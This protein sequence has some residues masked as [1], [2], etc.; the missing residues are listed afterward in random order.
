MEYH[1]RRYER[2]P[3]DADRCDR[4]GAC[5]TEC[6]VM[7]MAQ[8]DAEHVISTLPGILD[9]AEPDGVS[10]RALRDCTSCFTCNLVCP[11]DCR[12][13]N[14]FL[15]IWHAQYLREGLP[16]RARYFLPH[17]EPNFR[18]YVIDRLPAR[19][20]A[21]LDAWKSREPVKEI[22]FPGCNIVTT[23]YLTFSRLF[24]GL[25]I[26]GALEFCCGEMYFRMGL[27]EQMEQV[28]RKN[29][30][31]F[32][33][34][35]V[36]KVH[37]LCTAGL[38]LFTHVLPQFGA[39]F[40][41]IAFEPF[42]KRVHGLLASGELPIVKRFDGRTVTVQDSCHSKIFEEDFDHWPRRV[43]EL[44]GFEIVEAPESGDRMHCCGIAS[45]FSHDSA[46]SKTGMIRGQRAC[47]KNAREPGT[48]YIAAYCAGCMQMMSVARFMA[49]GAQPVHHVIE[50]V[51]EAIG[52]RPVRRQQR[53]AW[54]F[55]R[56]TL[57]GQ[58]IIGG[59]FFV[60]PIE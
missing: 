53:I 8:D 20:K 33:E 2:Q 35:G 59:R 29:T 18:T 39:D 58:K 9:G 37:M 5:L 41:G 25:P 13:A 27:Y 60:P 31:W 6:P 11:H 15:D 17:C 52:E 4:C 28:A 56:G 14:L 42:M 38:N 7:H 21:A 51:Q 1:F 30:A 48:D 19:E 40:S 3:F 22:F 47:L 54:D 55:L 24:D 57:T 45:G 26:R 16:A 43:L 49:W 10:R 50:L 34:L 46:Y 36:E 12:P 44:L 32:R 23:P